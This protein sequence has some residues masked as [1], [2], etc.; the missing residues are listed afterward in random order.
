VSWHVQGSVASARARYQAA[1]NPVRVAEPA[2]VVAD[3][4]TLAPPGIGPAA[5][6]T[7]SDLY[8]LIAGNRNLQIVA[9]HEMAA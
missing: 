1:G 3:T 6:A 5:G 2:F 9:T 4:A 8:P 7:F